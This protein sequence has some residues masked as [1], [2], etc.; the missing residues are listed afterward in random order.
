MSDTELFDD[1]IP[2]VP[3]RAR[4]AAPEQG[5]FDDLIPQ[6]PPEPAA[7]K[8]VVWDAVGQFGQGFNRGLDAMLNLPGQLANAVVN[9]GSE[10]LGL[11]PAKPFED[12]RLARRLNSDEAPQTTAGRYAGAIGEMAGSVVLP[13]AGLTL[14][15]GQ[16]ASRLPT[17]AETTSTIPRAFREMSEQIARRPGAAA[18]LDVASAA[19]AGAAGQLARDAGAGPLGET[20]ATLAGGMAPAVALAANPWKARAV[21]PRDEMLEAAGRLNVDV[22]YAFSLDDGSRLKNLAVKGGQIPFVGH[23]VQKAAVDTH[24]QLSGAAET[25]V[26]RTG[27]GNPYHAG[28]KV[29]DTAVTWMLSNS[30]DLAEQMYRVVDDAIAHPTM[31]HPLE[32][33]RATVAELVKEQAASA[34]NRYAP[35]I[36]RVSEALERPGLTYEGLKGLRTEIGALIDDKLM[37]E[38]GTVKP[39]LK[40]LYEALT[41]DLENGIIRA[42]GPDALQEWQ[43]ANKKF[44][45]LTSKRKAIEALVGKQGQASPTLVFDRIRKYAST[46]TR[47]DLTK[48]QRI[49]SIVG[50]EDWGDVQASVIAAMGRPGSNPD[51]PFS[52]QR[53]VTEYGKLSTRGREVLFG[54]QL[55]DALSDLHKV[56]Q[57]LVR[58]EKM[59]NPSGT[60]GVVTMGG[61]V[62]LPSVIGTVQFLLTTVLLKGG[63]GALTRPAVIRSTTQIARAHERYLRMQSTANRM[64]LQSAISA[65]AHSLA[66]ESGVSKD[67]IER[68]LERY[69]S[70][71]EGGN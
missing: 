71:Q 28:S 27:H 45:E 11:G 19:G 13:S 26:A 33:T 59:G 42:G 64:A 47:G 38:A 41:I 43:R 30:K 60:G 70:G 56:A 69:L 7:G 48:L 54:Q 40:R 65:W 8:S 9:V 66:Q 6:V 51:M 14:K 20:A 2:Q 23:P 16:V 49:K 57:R 52:P 18:A 67:E 62:A 61:M 22:P 12:I 55:S 5:L 34:S 68:A 3:P 25:M 44:I 53:F 37:P 31:L 15:A 58:V 32:K 17:V 1:L 50:K 63:L 29:K 10:A 35:A 21:T 46:S 4:Q 39:A 24:K 36:A